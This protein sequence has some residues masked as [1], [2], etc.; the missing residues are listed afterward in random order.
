MARTRREESDVRLY[1]RYQADIW[2]EIETEEDVVNVVV[3]DLTMGTPV[4]VVEDRPK[5]FL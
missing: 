1:L 4:D 3:D 5:T 2:F